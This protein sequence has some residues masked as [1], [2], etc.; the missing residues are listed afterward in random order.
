MMTNDGEDFN[1]LCGFN[2]YAATIGL[3]SGDKFH[4]PA[5]GQALILM[6]GDDWFEGME[7]AFYYNY[8]DI[9]H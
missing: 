1:C 4:C 7:D 2:T 3:D 5:C 8:V 6:T 9:I